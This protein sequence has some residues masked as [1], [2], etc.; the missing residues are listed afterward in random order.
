[1][2][3]KKIRSDLLHA[4]N[5]RFKPFAPYASYESYAP[6]P[7]DSLTKPAFCDKFPSQF[8]QFL[9][10]NDGNAIQIPIP[11]HFLYF[12]LFMRLCSISNTISSLPRKRLFGSKP[13]NTR[14]W[15]GEEEFSCP[16]SHCSKLVFPNRNITEAFRITKCSAS[17]GSVER[18]T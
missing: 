15:R 16:L 5:S 12:H 4:L 8:M 6:F 1:M 7:I 11:V 9:L 2:R 17:A 18:A 13:D 3:Y 10:L 14:A